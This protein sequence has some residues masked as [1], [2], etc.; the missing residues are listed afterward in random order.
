MAFFGKT[1]FESFRKLLRPLMVP[2]IAWTVVMGSFA[3]AVLYWDHQAHLRQ[4]EMVAEFLFKRDM[5]SRR[6]SASHGGVYV[7]VTEAT[8]PNPG[9]A[10]L[11]ER[12]VMTDQGQLLT[13]VNPAY[14][15]RLGQHPDLHHFPV[16]LWL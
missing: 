6:W 7:P 12:D 2:L 5:Q 13:L 16:R 15:A 8:P 3:L 4:A 10:F 14:M 1:K 9:L 11:P